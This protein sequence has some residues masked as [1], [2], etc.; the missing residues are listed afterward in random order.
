M[1]KCSYFDNC[2]S[3]FIPQ[4]LGLTERPLL[5]KEMS[6]IPEPVSNQ[7]T[8]LSL[9]DSPLLRSTASTWRPCLS[10]SSSYCGQELL[11]EQIG[12]A[13]TGK[14]K[15]PWHLAGFHLHS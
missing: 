10:C 7:E 3:K 15:S 4:A 8:S 1:Y 14:K 13:T 12:T 6:D 11:L 2:G 5:P 9:H